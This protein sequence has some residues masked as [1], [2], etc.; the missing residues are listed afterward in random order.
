MTKRTEFDLSELEIPC[1]TST[2][3][4]FL[5]P[6]TSEQRELLFAVRRK[7]HANEVALN[8]AQLHR[9]LADKGVLISSSVL[10]EFLNDDGTV[11]KEVSD[12]QGTT[13][14]RRKAG[15]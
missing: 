13:P 4:T 3:P 14:K 5:A 1:K 8:R 15:K 11:Y 10:K 12:G 9:W 7:W 2:R 6:L